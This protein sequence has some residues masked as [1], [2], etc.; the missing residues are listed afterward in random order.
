MPEE[1]SKP[2]AEEKVKPS[3]AAKPGAKAVKNSLAGSPVVNSAAS[4][5]PAPQKKTK[6]RAWTL[7]KLGAALLSVLIV[8]NLWGLIPG[9]TAKRGELKPV[10]V[11]GERGG[12]PDKPGR[13]CAPGN[14][15]VD[16]KHHRVALIDAFYKKV[17]FW[18][19]RDGSHIIDVD[20][21]GLHQI[22]PNGNPFD[23]GTFLPINGAFD[24]TGNFYVVDKSHGEVTVFSPDYKL[25]AVWPMIAQELTADNQD[26]VYILDKR[27]NELVRYNSDGKEL[28]RF[29]GAQFKDP[30]FMAADDSGRIFVVD[31]GQQKVLVFTRDGKFK[32]DWTLPL[33]PFGNPDIDA[34]GDKVYVSEHDK[35]KI[36]IFT[37]QG[38]LLAQY[39]IQYPTVLGVDA[40]G[41][42]YVSG[43]DAVHQYSPDEKNMP[44]IS[45]S[46]LGLFIRDEV[47]GLP[48]DQKIL[49]GTGMS[50]GYWQMQLSTYGPVL[51]ISLLVFW[52]FGLVLLFKSKP[53]DGQKFL[54]AVKRLFPD[55]PKVS[56]PV[57]SISQSVSVEEVTKSAKTVA[58]KTSGKAGKVVASVLPVGEEVP[59][60]A[61]NPGHP[62]LARWWNWLKMAMGLICIF[63]GQFPLWQGK[64]GHAVLWLLAG[65]VFLALTKGVIKAVMRFFQDQARTI[66][67]GGL[68]VVLTGFF[69]YSAYQGVGYGKHWDEEHHFAGLRQTV[70]SLVLLPKEYFYGGM[71]FNV[72]Y[73]AILPDVA[74]STGKYLREL[75][76]RVPVAPFVINYYTSLTELQSKLTQRLGDGYFRLKI[77][78][79]IIVL[80]S[81]AIGGMF[82]LSW[83]VQGSRREALLGACLMA[84]CWELNYHARWIAVDSLLAAFSTMVLFCVLAG[85]DAVS[86]DVRRRYLNVAAIFTGLAMSAKT[87]G[88]WLLAPMEV[89]LG[90]TIRRTSGASTTKFLQFLG[91]TAKVIALMFA[92]YLLT[93]PA[94]YVDF[95]ATLSYWARGVYEYSNVSVTYPYYATFWNHWGKAVVYFATTVSSPYLGIALVLFGF[96]LWG[97][98]RMFFQQR[99][100]FFI[101]LSFALPYA[102]YIGLGHLMI[103]RNL[104]ILLPCFFLFTAHG[105]NEFFKQAASKKKVTL[106]GWLFVAL[107]LCLNAF[108]MQHSAASV[109]YTDMNAAIRQFQAYAQ[110]HPGQ[111]FHLSPG[112][113][114]ELQNHKIATAALAAAP[115]QDADYAFFY[116]E[117]ESTTWVSNR[118]HFSKAVISSQELNYDYY[119]TWEGNNANTRII[120]MN[121]HN[122]RLMGVRF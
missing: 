55:K 32:D 34:R 62:R 39:D 20:K 35:H 71:Y 88:V 8:W 14:V 108:W 54:A 102:V 15:R 27:T 103:V 11:L 81:L 119:P 114:A 25:K 37:P 90:I 56:A 22:L 122:A 77:I 17:L 68:V 93:T 46:L 120:V 33:V 95:F 29:G 82:F 6:S 40:G 43:A 78:L 117:H 118:P 51:K 64:I 97:M 101:L 52:L 38:R 48:K 31:R 5:G 58:S 16:R 19:T 84:L 69:I 86:A 67:V 96:S 116:R 57:A 100:K 72:G 85:L 115:E 92:T 24:G 53:G 80:T 44:A 41:D 121:R 99:A 107:W 42:I 73:L 49:T 76:T 111:K 13:F 110:Q 75:K 18:N 61:L 50:A 79:W 23:D 45:T 7:L 2:A 91:G 74:A 10:R 98:Y 63:L 65:L 66:L 28:G 9:Q 104:L 36:L 47:L 83:S 113:R 109:K 106:A 4:Q 59:S 30:G 12:L 1:V 112:L 70:S 60:P 21:K 89:M 3:K 94:T 87:G 26:N 105:L